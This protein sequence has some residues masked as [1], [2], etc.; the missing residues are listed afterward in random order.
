MPYRLA[1][2]LIFI[3]IFKMGAVGV[4]LSMLLINVLYTVYMMYDLRNNNLITFCIDKKMLKA[5][6]KYSIPIMPH[7][8]STSIASFASRVFI[9][10]SAALAMVGLYSVGIQFGAVIDMI[11]SSVNQ[12]FAPWFYDVMNQGGEIGKREIV[13]LS[14]FL[15]IGYSLVYMLIGLFSPE[16][17]ILM[18]TER[19]HMA[20]TVIPILVVLIL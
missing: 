17:L 14:R 18:T 5:A 6:L 15:L 9:N 13:S 19:Y 8:L 16:V 10:K 1:F 3:G 2:T 20:W 11:Q 12:A 4:L 7:N